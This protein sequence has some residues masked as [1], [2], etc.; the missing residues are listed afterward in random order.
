[1]N[2]VKS[3]LDQGQEFQD[4]E[5]SLW[6]YIAREDSAASISEL[7]TY[8]KD[9]GLVEE[10]VESSFND[11][12]RL[13]FRLYFSLKRGRFRD[14]MGIGRNLLQSFVVVPEGKEDQFVTILEI[15]G[16]SFQ[17]VDFI[18]DSNDFYYKA[19]EMDPKN[20]EILVK[21]RGNYE[22]LRGANEIREI[23]RKIGEIVSPRGIDVSRSVNKG[24]TFQRSLICDGREISL[25]LQFGKGQGDREPLISIFFNGLVV[26]EDYL[27]GDVVSVPVESKV[28]ENV[29]QVVPVNMGVELVKISYE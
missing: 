28:G 29:L 16:E 5:D 7:E 26:W 3:L 23:N 15:V 21:L 2:Q 17:K 13:T 4:V 14:N 12:G 24:Q 1:L 22:R 20:L 19:L 9:K 6:E 8:L 18:Y 25:D 27:E 11:L 10:S